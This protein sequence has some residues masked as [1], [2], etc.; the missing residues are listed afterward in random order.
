MRALIKY[1]I[2]KGMSTTE[3]HEDI[4][5]TLGKKAPSYTTVKRWVA[6]FKRGKEDVKDYTRS[7][8]PI[9]V[10]T[11]QQIEA[12]HRAVK[13]DRRV[14]LRK[15]AETFSISLGSVRKNFSQ[16]LHMKKVSARWFPRTLTEDQKKTRVNMSKELLSLYQKDTEGFL[17]RTITQDETWVQHFDPETKQQ[18]MQWRPH[19]L[20]SPDLAPSD[21]YL[22]P[23]LKKELKGRQYSSDIEVIEGV[24]GV[25]TG[26]GQRVL[27]WRES[28]AWEKM[29]EVHWTMLKNNG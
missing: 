20:Y 29:E 13:D 2:L 1:H 14:T 12:V 3:I 7:R 28:E 19:P 16:H 22:F 6:D 10:V 15:L 8:R 27:L 11:D 17:A 24:L 23:K 26:E 21:F 25:L 4:M 9:D 18:S 5:Q